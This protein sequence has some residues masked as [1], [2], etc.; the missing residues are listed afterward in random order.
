M[1]TALSIYLFVGL[2]YAATVVYAVVKQGEGKELLTVSGL[3]VLMGMFLFWP[4]SLIHLLGWL[5]DDE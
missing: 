4:I 5:G 1:V 2:V 3:L